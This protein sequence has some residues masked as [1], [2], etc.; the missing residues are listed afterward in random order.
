[1]L[2]KTLSEMTMRALPKSIEKTKAYSYVRI[3]SKGQVDGT[4]IARQVAKAREY[5]EA[6]GLELDEELRDIGK[7]GFH[8]DH[9]KFG[10]LGTFIQLV[11]EGRVPVGSYLLVEALDRLSRE[12]VLIAQARFIDILLAGIY[13]VTLLDKQ[14]YHRDGKFTQLILSLSIMK[15]ANDESAK[16]SERIKHV[17][18]ARK[19]DIGLGLPRYNHHLVGWIDQTR[20]G[21]TKDYEFKLNGKAA[22]VRRIYEL[23]DEGVGAHTI[24]RI[25]NDEGLPVMR[26]KKNRRNQ[27]KDAS[28]WSILTN[29]TA[30]GTYHSRSRVDGKLITN[31]NPVPNFYPAAIDAELFWRV[32]RKRELKKAV[33]RKGRQYSNLFAR[34]TACAHCG[35]PLRFMK[36]GAKHRVTRYLTCQARHHNSNATCPPRCYRYDRFEEAVLV[37]VTDFHRAAMELHDAGKIDLKRVEREISRAD[38]K[39]VELEAARQN[40]ITM[41]LNVS[42]PRDRTAFVERINDIRG[43]MAEHEARRASMMARLRDISD[44]RSEMTAFSQKLDAERKMWTTS[45]DINQIYE[46]R[47]RV[48]AMLNEFITMVEVDFNLL[49]ATVWVAGFTSAYRFDNFGHLKASINLIS[50]FQP[51]GDR[52]FIIA[53]EHGRQ[54]SAR[55]LKTPVFTPAFDDQ[56]MINFMRS[57]GWPPE[58]VGPRHGG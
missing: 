26:E 19:D 8:G 24:A 38:K 55:K 58:L 25:L 43:K 50:M 52:P 48:S 57:M 37:Y 31:G 35:N 44:D 4:G 27:W 20:I 16:K 3:S 30:I 47:A 2:L 41:S 23:A 10:E 14:V 6:N 5:A 7:S 34:N 40:A 17:I 29:E 33:G 46:S 53:D 21:E 45:T 22:S 32:Q 36:G 42:D 11:K 39:L 28:V 9:V 1:M 54:Q 51:I 13:I 49:E 15:S 18:K 56:T 12:D